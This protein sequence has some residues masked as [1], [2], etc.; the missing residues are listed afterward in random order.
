MMIWFN[1]YQVTGQELKRMSDWPTREM[2]MDI[3]RDLLNAH[4]HS[5]YTILE[6]YET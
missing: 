2:A 5:K 3:I 4:P 6:V 1:V